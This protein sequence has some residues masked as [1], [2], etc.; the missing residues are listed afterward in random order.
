[1]THTPDIDPHLFDLYDEYCHSAMQRRD[2]LSRAAS[3]AAASGPRV[4]LAD[5][6]S[7]P[8]TRAHK[9][10]LSPTLASKRRMPPTTLRAAT[11]AR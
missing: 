4:V 3:I 2:F 8:T 9:R 1:M 6:H 5:K 11:A 10:Y 7:Y